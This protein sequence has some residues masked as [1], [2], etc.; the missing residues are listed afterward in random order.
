M[1]TT[2]LVMAAVLT[3]LLVVGHLGCASKRRPFSVQYEQ[4]LHPSLSDMRPELIPA[5]LDYRWRL[6]PPVSAGLAWFREAPVDSSGDWDHV[7]VSGY[8][9]TG[10]LDAVLEALRDEPF[11]TVVPLPVVPLEE[12]TPLRWHTVDAVRALSARFQHDVALLLETGIVEE[13]RLNPFAIGYLGLITIPFFPGTDLG[14]RTSAE[15]CAVE[16]RSGVML[17]CARG[18]A[19]AADRFLFPLQV[20]R[21]RHELTEEALRDSVQGAAW[22]LLPKLS[23]RVGY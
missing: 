17:A 22:G 3:V 8:L 6:T 18:R 13:K 14:I 11:M 4:A 1:L 2:R 15:I 19:V 16:V 9:R 20:G 23:M 21:R 5:A 12:G 7:P 10:V